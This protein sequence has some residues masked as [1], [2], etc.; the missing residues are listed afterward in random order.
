MGNVTAKD[1]YDMQQQLRSTE[2]RVFD[3]QQGRVGNVQYYVHSQP[4]PQGYEIAQIP[5]Q[6][7][8]FEMPKRNGETVVVVKQGSNW[9]LW[10]SVVI[11][12][13]YLLK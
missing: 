4:N 12:G 2:Q 10:T 3:E 13:L 6:R 11:G 9:L 8:E 5:I 7:E 1:N